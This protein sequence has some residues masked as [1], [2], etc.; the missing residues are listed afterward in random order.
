MQD[1]S[2]S[3]LLAA[4]A[5]AAGEAMPA[6]RIPAIACSAFRAPVTG[7]VV[8]GLDAAAGAAD[9]ALAAGKATAQ[10][11]SPAA[12]ATSPEMA[13]DLKVALPVGDCDCH[14]I[15]R[16]YNRGSYVIY[17]IFPFMPL[18]NCLSAAPHAEHG[19]W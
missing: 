14:E 8:A 5:A 19:I 7:M 2:M 1:T 3:W 11:P 6:A 15:L 10:I 9:V 17:R 12:S 13:M 16:R 18:S 4:G